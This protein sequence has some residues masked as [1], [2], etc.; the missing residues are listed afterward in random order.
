M[1]APS[2]IGLIRVME[3]SEYKVFQGSPYD[4]NLVGIRATERQAGAFDD[5]ICC[6]FK[7]AGDHWNY[8]AWAATTDPGSDWLKDLGNPRGTA[9]LKPGQYRGAY[10]LGRHRG[11][12]AALVQ[13]GP[14]TVFRDADRD[15]ELDTAGMPEE[16]GLFGINIHRARASGASTVVGRWSAGCQVIARAEDFAILISICQAAVPV[17]GNS[18]SYTLLEQSDFALVGGDPEKQH[19]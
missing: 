3:A 13:R 18:F 1:R 11:Q 15:N 5:L 9:I 10:Q 7:N 6:F 2:L 19:G 8:F 17:W 14:V 16:T 12:Y 4:L